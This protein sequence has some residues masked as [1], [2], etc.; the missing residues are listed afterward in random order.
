MVLS[1]EPT[2]ATLSN[3][4]RARWVVVAAV[5]LPPL[6]LAGLGLDHP[7]TLD[8]ATAD[9][10]RDLHVLLLPLFPLLGLAPWMIARRDS[11]L[12]GWAA[13]FFGYV[14]GVFYTALDVLAGI[15]A[16]AVQSAGLSAAVEVMFTRG[17]ALGAVGVL[18]YLA[19]TLVAAVAALRQARL[20]AA[21]GATLVVAGAVSFLNSHIYW[22]R[23]VL[24]LVVLA[25]GWALLASISARTPQRESA[26]GAAPR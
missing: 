10:W 16:G 15:G 11:R 18:A 6:L 20:A 25:V 22:P 8:A 19:A 17:D 1:G 23:G 3:M 2:G 4:P 5:G 24:T 7:A 26:V 12:L 9:R 21:P 14:Y 13:G